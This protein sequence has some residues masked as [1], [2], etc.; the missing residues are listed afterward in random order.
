M[1]GGCWALTERDGNQ[2]IERCDADDGADD[3]VIRFDTVPAGRYRLEEVT[4][5]PG[6]QP[7]DSQGIDVVAGPP[8]RARSNISKRGAG[9]AA[10]HPRRRR[11]RRSDTASL[12]RRARPVELR[13]VCDRQ[14]DGQLNVPDLPAGEYTVTQTQTAEVSHRLPRRLSPCPRTTPSNFHS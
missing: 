14:D 11:E 2:S 6:Y 12:L 4:T 10:D 7:A 3:G 1:S 5:P 9:R 8:T 13:E